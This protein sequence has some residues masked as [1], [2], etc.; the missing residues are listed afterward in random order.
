[1]DMKN[2][3]LALLEALTLIA[4]LVGLGAF[5]VGIDLGG[6]DLEKDRLTF[7]M[8]LIVGI[9]W[10]LY[11]FSASRWS[12][13]LPSLDPRSS[14]EGPLS[15]FLEAQVKRQ[16]LD[17]S[18]RRRLRAGASEALA[19]ELQS[20][21]EPLGPPYWLATGQGVLVSLGLLG[22]FL[23]LSLGLLQAV[24]ELKGNPE[25]MQ[26]GMGYLLDGAKLAFVKSLAGVLCAMV[27]GLRYRQLEEAR[28]ALVG[29]C[30]DWL[31]ERY[32]PVSTEEL[33][34]RML[35]EQAVASGGLV[36]RIER[37]EKALLGEQQRSTEH[38]AGVIGWVQERM[39][40]LNHE[41]SGV[42]GAVE[43]VGRRVS[44]EVEQVRGAVLHQEQAVVSALQ[45]LSDDERDR[46]TE[47]IDTVRQLAE[48][49]PQQ[50]GPNVGDVLS[51][52]IGPRLEEFGSALAALPNHIGPAV[53]VEL[54]PNLNA[55]TE[56]LK[57]L[58]DVQ[59][60]AIE[61]VVK[62]GTEQA[63]SDLGKSLQDVA[64]LL[65][66]LPDQLGA[67]VKEAEGDV[68]KTTKRVAE[69]LETAGKAVAAGMQVATSDLAGA[70]DRLN[71]SI[72]T[73][74]ALTESLAGFGQQIQTSLIAAKESAA[75]LNGHAKGLQDSIVKVTQP[76]SAVSSRLE[77]VPSALNLATEAMKAEQKALVGVGAELKVQAEAIRGQ[78]EALKAR[79]AEYQQLQ[80]ALSTQWGAQM[81]GVLNANQKIKD[82]WTTAINAAQQG[83][84]A[85]ALQIATY[86]EKVEKSV[87]VPTD[88]TN[89]NS[90]ILDLVGVLDDLKKT[91][92]VRR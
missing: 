75:A 3:W 25:A 1:M 81:Q 5:G 34:A 12:R 53:A 88:L 57:R 27:W 44:S 82:A 14:D 38:I 68:Q 87:R 23:G 47:L 83:V 48:Q 9:A 26:K 52:L 37:M 51:K 63:V 40:D 80:A 28:D 73:V 18:G 33:M 69:E 62:K 59:G 58:G 85:N 77:A 35:A 56:A 64:D 72:V 31:D 49:L 65:Q 76:L 67:R 6:L 50:I 21:P 84:Q 4:L 46:L 90:A 71:E 43:E 78:H 30:K 16:G 70:H 60:G 55:L 79:I 10:G 29:T 45:T 13:T 39:R 20:R 2:P 92:A 86:A 22:T 41:V 24:P 8:L 54:K 11:R 66:K 15:D 19:E 91:L 32:P 74:G 61:E 89:L 36:E 7:V 17:V 42:G